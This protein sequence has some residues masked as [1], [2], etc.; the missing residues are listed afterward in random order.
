[1]TTTDG[2]SFNLFNKLNEGKYV[3]VDFFFTTCPSCI[4]T[5]P[6]YKE[7]FQNYGCNTQ[8]VYFISMDIG[9]TDM[10]VE[11]YESD[12]YSGADI[13]SVSGLQ[14]NG[15]SVV[16]AY[17]VGQF[18]TY[19]LIAPNKDIVEQDMWPISS[20]ASFDA[21]LSTHGLTHKSCLSAGLD[22]NENLSLSVY[23]NPT[24]DRIT[25]MVDE[26]ASVQ[27]MQLTNALGQTVWST[28][29]GIGENTVIDLSIFSPGVYILS[30]HTGK[31]TY[32]HRILRN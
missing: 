27:A 25:V 16:P 23:P 8:D 19:I 3:L 20:A 2:Q 22:E 13:P 7:A 9:D 28:T 10:E 1:V 17:G 6:F 14:G 15:N 12:Y 5:A 30:V 21:Y 18:P 24:A 4:Q 26:P 11:L 32:Q 29:T 31:G